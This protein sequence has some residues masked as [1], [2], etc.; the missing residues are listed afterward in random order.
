[1]LVPPPLP[2]PPPMD[3]PRRDSPEGELD[4]ELP[5]SRARGD[6]TDAQGGGL[7]PAAEVRQSRRL[8]AEERPDGSCADIIDDA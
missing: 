6:R 2:P 4:G 1:M 7:A 3:S 8:L 5:R